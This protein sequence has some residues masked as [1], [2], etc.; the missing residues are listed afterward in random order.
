MTCW[1]GSPRPRRD[2]RPRI[3]RPQRRERP[4]PL[5]TVLVN[6]ERFAGPICQ[7]ANNIV[8]TPGTVARLLFDDTWAE[9]IVF[10][11]DSRPI[12]IGH[13]RRLFTGATRRAVQVAGQ[14]CFDNT[15][16]TPAEDCQTDHIIPWSNNGPTTIA[17][18]QPA[19]PFHNRRKRDTG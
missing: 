6:Y 19:C 4:E 15:C 3:H 16:E 14:E 13:R 8:V 18:G 1:T 12:D 9:R 7:L 11:P 10:G 17:N 2:G 5:L